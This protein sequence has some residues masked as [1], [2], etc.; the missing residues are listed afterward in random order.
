MKPPTCPRESELLEQLAQGRSAADCDPALR[1]HVTRCEMCREVVSVATALRADCC[2]LPSPHHLPTASQVWW[3]AQVRAR[4]EAAQVAER[5]ITFAQGAAGAAIV[6][7]VASVVGW[8][9][10]TQPARVVRELAAGAT[11][12]DTTG[13]LSVVAPSPLGWALLV[14]CACVLVLMP[15]AVV[16]A[17]S[18]E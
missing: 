11:E 4:F 12:A 5:P 17:L 7:V 10:V 6:G 2:D 16:L 3:R 1:Q 18:D 8:S 13:L 9:W 15:I 14:T